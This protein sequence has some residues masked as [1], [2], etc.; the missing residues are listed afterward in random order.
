M[1]QFC[2]RYSSSPCCRD[3]R[4]ILYFKLW[5]GGG[6]ENGALKNIASVNERRNENGTE[7]TVRKMKELKRPLRQIFDAVVCSSSSEGALAVSFIEI[8]PNSTWLVTSR[9]DT[10]RHVRRVERVETSVSSA[11]SRAVLTWRTTNKL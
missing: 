5:I 8:S 3:R 10:A 4:E 9:L 2:R 7:T 6:A 1:M 11:S